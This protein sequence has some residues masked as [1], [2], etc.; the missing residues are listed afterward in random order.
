M[1]RVRALK[2]AGLVLLVGM[3]LGVSRGWTGEARSIPWRSTYE[4][5]FQEAKQTGKPL[6]VQF[7]GPWCIHCK[8]MELDALIAPE[9]IGLADGSVI[10]VKVRSDE[11]EDLTQRYR[12]SGLP[13][14]V[15]VHPQG[16]VLLRHEGYAS[17]QQLRMLLVR[18]RGS[19]VDPATVRPA[20]GLEGN[21][22]VTLVETGK[23]EAGS[24]EWTAAYDGVTYRF[25]G[26]A[27]RERFAQA[28]ERYVP[29]SQ[30]RCP[31]SQAEEGRTVLGSPRYGVYHGGRL[32]LFASAEAR[33]AFIDAPDRYRD[34]DLAHAGVCPV[35]RNQTGPPA[36][37][38]PNI[39]TIR[40]GIR[41]LFNTPEHLASFR[42]SL[43]ILRR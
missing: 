42:E 28:P 27:Q 26:E 19:V 8:R 4:A 13:T 24:G 36:Q 15:L 17:T 38:S 34:L 3:A 25:A 43:E 18:A 32:F 37:G 16:M 11:R 21:C 29:M 14:T 22:P 12:V 41:Y 39:M 40:N 7:T 20:L 23:L 30:G 6:W 9:V 10:P 31:V 1:D 2:T 35:C 33:A 5:A